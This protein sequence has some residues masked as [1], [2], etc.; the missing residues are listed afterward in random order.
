MDNKITAL[1]CRLSRDDELQG[2]SNSI[3][4]QKKILEKYAREN[5]FQ[6]IHFFIDDGYSGVDFNRPEFMKMENLINDGKVSTVITKDMSRFG[7]NYLK[8][9]YYLDMLFPVKD[10]RFIAIN[11]NVDTNK[12]IDDFLPFKNVINEWYAKDASKKVKAAKRAIGESGRHTSSIPPFGYK[13]SP[14]DKNQWIVDEYSAEVVKRIF[15]MYVSGYGINRISRI[16]KDEGILTPRRYKAREGIVQVDTTDE[17]YSEYWN[18]DTLRGILENKSYLGHTVNFKTY[19]LSYKN[20][21]IFYNDES[22]QAVFYNTH[23]PIIDEEV[24]ETA[25]RLLGN[26]RGAT[27][28]DMIDIF[29]GLMWCADCGAKMYQHRFAKPK[30]NCYCCGTYVKNH[31][32]SIHSIKYDVL[33]KIV[34]EEITKIS[35][36]VCKDENGF[37]KKIMG[38][39]EEA[40][41]KRI[42]DIN[43]KLDENKTRIAELEQIFKKLFTEKMTKNI[44]K[45]QFDVF[46]EIYNQEY[47]ELT[48][49]VADLADE[50]EKIESESIDINKFIR[51]VK[52]YSTKVNDISDMDITMTNALIDKI[53]CHK[54]EGKGKKKK[55]KLDIY[56]RGIGKFSL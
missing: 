31:G 45:K 10:I 2:E 29:S 52:K 55:Q 6:N 19:R 25:Q 50:I 11:D 24:F 12:G 32:C 33:C 48:A 47:Q 49:E 30:Y 37:F 7:R 3:T 8:I 4:T 21:K 16:L 23:E 46:Y 22:E 42:S 43:K 5:H 28:Y 38:K 44:D 27:R 39:F 34:F 54:A 51:N 20:H 15:Q 56:W 14:T 17:S 41:S 35:E 40:K 1:Y 26:K 9:G 53:I 13:K 36:L 18:H